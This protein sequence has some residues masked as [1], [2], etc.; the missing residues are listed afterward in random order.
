MAR[1]IIADDDELIVETV[2]CALEAR[3]HVVGA[4]PDGARVKRVVETK[5]PD[6]VILD[7]AMP[8][9]SG[10]EALRQIRNSARTYSTP[11]LMLTARRSASDEEIAIRAGA[12]DYLRKPF[13]PDQLVACVEALLDHRSRASPPPAAASG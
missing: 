8:H 10:V 7:C 4:L 3:G 6:V 2:R 1:I 5:R 13:C 9:V 11:V 12:D